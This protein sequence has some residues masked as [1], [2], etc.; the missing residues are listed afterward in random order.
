MIMKKMASVLFG[1]T[2]IFGLFCAGQ[3]QAH[4]IWLAPSEQI[5]ATPGDTVSV[6]VYLHADSA[7]GLQ[8]WSMT[9]GFDDTAVDGSELTYDSI[10]Y[11]TTDLDPSIFTETYELGA[12]QNQAGESVIS[13]VSRGDL[14]NTESLTADQDFL[15]FTVN[16]TFDGGIWDGEDVWIEWAA[17][18]DGFGFDSGWYDTLEVVYADG[19]GPDYAA[20]PIPGAALLLGSGLLGLVGIRRK[21]V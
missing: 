17:G 7:D 12:S 13:Y 4:Y 19:T 14:S 3:A 1:I 8:M 21:T 11:G 15:L 6:D 16:F 9:L 2:M 5:T 20:V 10:T 18:M